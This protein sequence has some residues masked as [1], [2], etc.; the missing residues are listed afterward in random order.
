MPVVEQAM[1]PF[2]SGVNSQREAPYFCLFAELGRG[3]QQ[4]YVCMVYFLP[5]MPLC[6]CLQLEKCYLQHA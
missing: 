1:N 5:G 3:P 6:C 2:V 4:L